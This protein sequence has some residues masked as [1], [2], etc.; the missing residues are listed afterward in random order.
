MQTTH[1]IVDSLR[2]VAGRVQ[3]GLGSWAGRADWQRRGLR[4]QVLARA[5]HHLLDIQRHAARAAKSGLVIA[6]PWPL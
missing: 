6:G 1:Y 2:Q 5:D 4:L 3:E